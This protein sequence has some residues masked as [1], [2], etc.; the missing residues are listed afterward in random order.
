MKNRYLKTYSGLP[1]ELYFI[2]AAKVINCMGSFILPLL[3]LILS[4]KLGMSKAETGNFSALLLLTQVPSLII[5][6]KL[7][8]A[9]GRKKII[10]T[11]EVLGSFFYFLC[12]F[13]KDNI[14]MAL[15]I[16]IAENLYTAAAPAF[17]S[18]VADI[19]TPENRKASF[20]LLYLGVNIGMTISPLL[21]G[22]L[23][24]DHLP[25][26]FLLDAAT[27]LASVVLLAVFVKET[28]NRQSEPDLTDQP[29]ENIPVYRVL[30]AVPLLLIFF[31][32]IFIYDFA[33][34]QWGFMLPLQFGD[35]YGL[36]G[37]HFF[38]ILAALN[39]LIVITCTPLLTHLTQRF[40][41][42]SVIAGGGILYVVAYSVFSFANSFPLFLAAV[43]L[44]TF[45]EIVVAINIGAFI[46]DHSPNAHRG[47]INSVLMFTRGSAFALGPF[48]MGHVISKT[49][50]CVTWSVMVALMLFGTMG[51]LLLG[52]KDQKTSL[53]IAMPNDAV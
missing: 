51:M 4:Q 17:D 31:A 44:F 1:K 23:F 8:D 2:F 16:V 39:S 10:I 22:L 32:L 46:A 50:Y 24:K 6:G 19:T 20:S 27:T 30:K 35:L 12:G 11:C 14:S 25:L 7:T 41:P 43:A 52:R 5:G 34:S 29:E 18:M 49:S 42:L 15:F 9:I 37:A 45:G 36:D 3:T 28:K 13:S 38:S 33:Y 26:L 48:I 53:P 21:G 40:R 47:R